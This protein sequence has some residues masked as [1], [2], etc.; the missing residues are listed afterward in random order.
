MKLKKLKHTITEVLL[1]SH[2]TLLRR[3]FI[4]IHVIVFQE[5]ILIIRQKI[6]INNKLK[7]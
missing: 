4:L 6:K 3:T 1:K 7:N 5:K 2:Q